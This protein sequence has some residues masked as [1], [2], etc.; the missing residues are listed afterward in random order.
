[1]WIKQYPIGYKNRQARRA[2]VATFDLPE[3]PGLRRKMLGQ[4]RK[5]GRGTLDVELRRLARRKLERKA[6]Q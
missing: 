3:E 4:R 1:M 2:G 6:K 5:K